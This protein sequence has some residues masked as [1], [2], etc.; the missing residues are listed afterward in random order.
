[1]TDLEGVLAEW[2]ALHYPEWYVAKDIAANQVP[3]H[4][5]DGMKRLKRREFFEVRLHAYAHHRLQKTL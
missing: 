5:L 4:L 1:M 3:V 2:I